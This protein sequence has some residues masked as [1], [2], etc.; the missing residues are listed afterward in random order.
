MAAQEDT[1]DEIW[2]SLGDI[3]IVDHDGETHL[4][5]AARAGSATEVDNL[6]R[7]GAD[8]NV[9]NKSGQ[10]PLHLAVQNYS[11][12]RR[13]SHFRARSDFVSL[14]LD[15]G[16]DVNALTQKGFNPTHIALKKGSV[17]L[18]KMLLTWE[19]DFRIPFP[20]GET[21]VFHTCSQGSASL[22]QVLL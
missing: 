21:L 20:N 9:K 1:P 14:L 19:A 6:I 2:E 16:A 18:L 15:S 3:N 12:H 7:H 22:L 4:H 10:T 8:A 11:G 5:Y 13:S 17:P